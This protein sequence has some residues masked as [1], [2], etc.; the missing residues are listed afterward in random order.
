MLLF[1]AVP[2]IVHHGKY[3]EKIPRYYRDGTFAI[4]SNDRPAGIA[5]KFVGGRGM[6]T[7]PEVQGGDVGVYISQYFVNIITN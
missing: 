5:G 2:P 7:V 6:G 4:T 1:L 3:W